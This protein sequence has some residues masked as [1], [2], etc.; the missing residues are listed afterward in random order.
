MEL[1]VARFEKVILEAWQ[2]LY[3]T[4]NCEA[5]TRIHAAMRQELVGFVIRGTTQLVSGLVFCY[6]SVLK[7]TLSR[8]TALF[9]TRLH[10]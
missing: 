3:Y 1:P 10:V 8:S 5:R 7:W 6:H 9:V 4:V 2:G